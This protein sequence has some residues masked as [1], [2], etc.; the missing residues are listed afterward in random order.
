MDARLTDEAAR[1]CAL[2]RY[3]V[4]NTPPEAGFERLTGLVCT[5]LDVPISAV[6]LIDR[7][8]QW[9]KSVRGLSATETPRDISFCAHTIMAREPLTIA[10]ATL[11]PRFAA[12]PLVTGAPNIRSYA[13]VPL[14]TPD[15][16]NLGSLCAIDTRARVFSDAQIALLCDFGALAVEELE[17][18]TI[19]RRDFVTG[20]MTRRA[21]AAGVGREIDRFTRHGRPSSL[22]VF[23]IDHFKAINDRFGHQVGDEVLKAMA[24]ACA[25]GLRPGDLFGRV[26]GEEFA[27]CLPDTD[28]PTALARAEQLRAR[29][30]RMVVR[31]ADFPRVT[32]S[33]G[34]ATLGESE[35]YAE[36][37]DRA[38]AAM[39][40]AKR[41][42]RDQC[43]ARVHETGRKAAA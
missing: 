10:D 36:W 40:D 39:Y 22:V 5:V 13:G 11:D 6:S 31:N 3:Q 37:F 43:R 32:A 29:V 30:N 38:D 41:N 28:L 16:Y 12:N 17:L 23:D 7:E 35:T 18:R 8:R 27:V 19:A 20:A 34:V 2:D 42:G 14:S 15:G 4:L 9:F 24:Q 1:L 26:G 25:T 33:F 21:F